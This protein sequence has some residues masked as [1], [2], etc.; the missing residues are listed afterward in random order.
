MP[1]NSLLLSGTLLKAAAIYTVAVIIVELIA[2]QLTQAVH[3]VRVTAWIVEHVGVPLARTAALLLFI[4]AAYPLLYGVSWA[5]PLTTVL[6]DNGGHLRYLLNSVFLVTL[7]LPLLP[8][9]IARI[10]LI[11]PL[12]GVT[13]AALLFHWIAS[14]MGHSEIDY[15]PGNIAALAIVI[16][17]LLIGPFAAAIGQ[18]SGETIDRLFER[19][20]GE[21]LVTDGVTLLLQLPLLLIYTL[22]VGWQLNGM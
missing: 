13:A 21:Q 16:L 11:L 15:W 22:S 7:L 9:S 4:F 6:F 17:G 18:F 3:H 5:P 20:D 10:Q 14:A 12:Q 2:A 1:F 19:Y 8:L